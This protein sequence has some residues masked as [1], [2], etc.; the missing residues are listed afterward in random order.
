MSNMDK[1]TVVTQI[2]KHDDFRA[3]SSRIRDSL[4][5]VFHIKLC[6]GRD[7]CTDPRWIVLE[8]AAQKCETFDDQ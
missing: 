8:V 5:V 7:L 3:F 4:D 6:I 2:P 1:I